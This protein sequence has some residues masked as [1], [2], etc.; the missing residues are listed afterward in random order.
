MTQSFS[1]MLDGHQWG[2]N[3]SLNVGSFS[4]RLTWGDCACLG[5]EDTPLIRVLLQADSNLL[6]SP[7]FDRHR[8]RFLGAEAEHV[9]CHQVA[10]TGNNA[11]VLGSLR[12][13]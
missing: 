1:L 12:R 6:S 7:T 4:V 5:E 2:S 11:G 13:G 9:R 3:D 8:H 10:V